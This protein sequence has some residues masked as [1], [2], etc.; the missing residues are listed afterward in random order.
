MS[1]FKKDL[2]PVYDLDQSLWSS[3][4]L[5]DERKRRWV[6][7]RR[8]VW[9][10]TTRW[11]VSWWRRSVRWPLRGRRRRGSLLST[12]S[13]P[14]NL[15]AALIN[16]YPFSF[17]MSTKKITNQSHPL[18][19]KRKLPRWY[20]LDHTDL[21]QLSHR[22]TTH[23]KTS[24]LSIVCPSQPCTKGRVHHFNHGRV[25]KDCKQGG[26]RSSQGKNQGL[27]RRRLPYSCCSGFQSLKLS[28]KVTHFPRKTQRQD[29]TW[30]D[31]RKLLLRQ[32]QIP[33]LK[34]ANELFPS[35]CSWTKLHP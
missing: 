22:R 17:S 4:S 24:S 23:K 20:I 32:K 13:L 35:D 26:R 27:D 29:S 30:P 7:K 19:A 34:T 14:L 8:N 11:D 2:V 3:N 6:W 18:T 33:E 15:S 21:Y 28:W 9:L 5:D 25:Q 31:C 1:W 16:V 10:S 12:C